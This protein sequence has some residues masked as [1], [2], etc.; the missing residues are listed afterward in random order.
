MPENLAELSADDELTLWELWEMVRPAILPALL[1]AVFLAGLVYFLS[2][3]SPA[4]YRAEAKV[5]ILETGNRGAAFP[6]PVPALDPEAYR[7]VALSHGLRAVFGLEKKNPMRAR[8]EKGRRSSILTLS[9]EDRDPARA[10][11]L[12][13]AWVEALRAWERARVEGQLER[14]AEA[15]KARLEVLEKELAEAQRVGDATRV[16]ALERLKAD[17]LRDLDWV[18]AMRVSARGNLEVLEPA[19]PPEAPVAPRPLLNAALAGF[20]SFFGWIFLVF[21]QKALDPR[22]RSSEEVARLLGLPILSEF[23]R[24]PAGMGRELSREAANFL[25]V[26]VDRL[27]TGEDPK[28]VVVTSA[29]EGAGKSSV[30]LALARAYARTERPVLLVDADLR[31]PVLDEELGQKSERGLRALLEDPLAPIEPVRVEPFFDFL[32]AGGTMEASS[33]FLSEH[34]RGFVTRLVELGRYDAVVIDSAPLL[35]VADTLVVVPHAS[36]VVLV[37]AE[38]RTHKRRLAAAVELLKRVGARVLGV[39]VTRV[40]NGVFLGGG[41]AGY[42]YPKR[43]SRSAPAAFSKPRAP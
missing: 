18:R 32:P 13:N 24:V 12:A 22:L 21:T 8:L 39:A 17:L 7:Q 16:G 30:A 1:L 2:A 10:A 27:L 25:R 9:V 11:E 28:I 35:P 36:G 26:A 31:Q 19:L 6:E 15:F 5:L 37:A 42:G 43:S 41:Y 40:R 23:P 3:R 34:W 29:E 4:V 14:Q 38:G 33:E 20:L